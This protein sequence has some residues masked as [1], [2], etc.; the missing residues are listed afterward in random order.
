MDSIKWFV[1]VKSQDELFTI[2]AYGKNEREARITGKRIAQRLL[3]DPLVEVSWIKKYR[4]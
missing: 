1:R 2:T 4:R 3:N